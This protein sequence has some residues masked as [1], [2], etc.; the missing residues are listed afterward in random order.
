MPTDAQTWGVELM[1]GTN[2]SK[3]RKKLIPVPDG[4]DDTKLRTAV[5]TAV[6]SDGTLDLTLS[7]VAVLAVPRLGSAWAAVGSVVQVLSYRGSLLVLGVVSPGPAGDLTKTGSVST[8]PSAA[9]SFTTVVNFGVT[10]PGLPSVMI[11]LATSAGSTSGWA[12]RATSITTTGFTL[13]GFGSS[14]TFST[15]WQ[16]TATY[17]P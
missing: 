8:G 10:F 12:G 9:T 4:Q 1:A 16:W 15:A 2:L 7:G 6:N 5:V 13:F 14:A 11:N 3:L 17:A